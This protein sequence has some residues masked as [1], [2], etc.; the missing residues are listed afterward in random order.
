MPR[1]TQ[2]GAFDGMLIVHYEGAMPKRCPPSG[3]ASRVVGVW[4]RLLR[5]DQE[6]EKR[7]HGA[8]LS[9]TVVNSCTTIHEIQ[10]DR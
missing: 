10:E 9:M 5:I 2:I 1:V 6:F 8:G 7:G 4:A 3:T